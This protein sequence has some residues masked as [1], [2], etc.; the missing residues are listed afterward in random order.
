MEP[1]PP[2]LPN[3][4]T[5]ICAQANALDEIRLR[6]FLD[7]LQTHHHTQEQIVAG[8]LQVYLSAWFETL[9]REGVQ[10]ENQLI[11]DEIA[12]WRGLDEEKLLRLL[13][14]NR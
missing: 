7:W 12:W 13:K 6:N 14:G 4:V 10:W 1:T 8:N 11:L 9:S 2:L 5:D 3:I